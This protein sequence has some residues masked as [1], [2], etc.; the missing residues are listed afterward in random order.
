MKLLGGRSVGEGFGTTD[1]GWRGYG[2]QTG[3]SRL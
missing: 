2:E 3:F 1:D